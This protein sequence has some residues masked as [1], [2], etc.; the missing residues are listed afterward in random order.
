MTPRSAFALFAA[1][2]ALSACGGDAKPEQSASGERTDSSAGLVIPTATAYKPTGD[3]ASAALVVN[4][5]GDPAAPVPVPAC[6]DAEPG[7]GTVFWVEGIREGKP[8]PN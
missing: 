6:A 8:L 1:A 4:L 5:V 2:V 3:I 7:P